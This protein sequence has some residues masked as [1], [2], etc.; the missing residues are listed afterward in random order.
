MDEE[1]EAGQGDRGELR[2]QVSWR[3]RSGALARTDG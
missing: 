3:S 2:E 1:W